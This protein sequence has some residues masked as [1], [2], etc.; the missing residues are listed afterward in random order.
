MMRVGFYV[1]DE[2]EI[3][4]FEPTLDVMFR[5]RGKHVRIFHQASTVDLK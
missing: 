1:F 2:A 5:A 4:Q 3:D